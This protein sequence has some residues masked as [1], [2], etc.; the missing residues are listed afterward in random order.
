[1]PKIENKY[2]NEIAN[3][4]SLTILELIRADDTIDNNQWVLDNLIIE[5]KLK[6]IEEDGETDLL[7]VLEED[8]IAN[9]LEY[10]NE[11]A[12]FY[13][14]NYFFDSDD[15]ECDFKELKKFVDACE[16]LENAC[17]DVF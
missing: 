16:A 13:I 2:I 10:I 4:I 3:F 1:M 14:K 17:E 9:L 7:E 15:T 11:N 6:D 8:E 12:G 5:K